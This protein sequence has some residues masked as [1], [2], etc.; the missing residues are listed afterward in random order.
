MSATYNFEELD[1]QTREYLTA[2]RDAEGRGSP[3]IF[4]STTDPLPGVGCV[5][6]PLVIIGTLLGTLIPDRMV[7]ND[8]I[9]LAMLQTAGLLLGAWLITAKL[10]MSAARRRLAGNWVYADPLF[11]Y[12]AFR[13][14]VTLIPLDDLAEARVTHN[15]N[16]DAY[17]NSALTL[18]FSGRR[19]ATVTIPNERR[20]D[21]LR[22]YLN[23]VA[24]ARGPEGGTRA[25]LSPAT[26]GGVARYV[27]RNDDEPT[28]AEGGLNLNLVELDITEVPEEPSRDGRALPS[29]LPYVAMILFA[30]ACFC[31]FAWVV[32]PPLRDDAL[33]DLIMKEPY[34]EPQHLRAYLLDER[35]KLHRDAVA[36]RLAQFY[37]DPVRHVQRQGQDP[38]LRE[39]MAKVLD[40][41][42]TAEQPLA[43]L[44]VTEQNTPPGTEGNKAKREKE[45]RTQL[46]NAIN[47]EFSRQPW[48]QPIRVPNEENP[49]PRS[50]IGEQLIAF[51]E[52][53]EGADKVHFDITYGVEPAENGAGRLAATVTIRTNINEQPVATGTLALPGTFDAATLDTQVPRLAAGL[54]KAMVGQTSSPPPGMGFPQPPVIIPP[55][56]F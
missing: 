20:A 11:L 22:T 52:A 25:K 48:G 54:A 6:G 38:E 36:K 56:K 44:R 46:V 43:S 16:N 51:I 15:Y 10:R 28:D 3:G 37:D 13:E 39:G 29:V 31:A 32:D 42:R 53:P 34:V 4:A 55:G 23:Y 19:Q 21:Q 14:Q 17:T 30:A 8:P 27:A 12:Q 33:Y 41:L 50:P 2:V 24:W 47:A 18:L 45:L 40:S 1:A 35:N 7:L 9:G 5:V 49:P 26:L